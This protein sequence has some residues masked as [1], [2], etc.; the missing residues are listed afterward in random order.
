MKHCED[1]QVLL[2]KY[3]LVRLMGQQKVSPNTVQAYKDTFRLY[4]RYLN[5]DI[6]I[7]PNS[8]NMSHFTTDT[9]IGFLK[10]LETKRNN[11]AK[12]INN[13]LAAI[14][15]FLEFV[16]YESPEYLGNIRKIK[17]IPFRKT[18]KKEVAYL[19]KNEI[20]ALLGACDQSDVEGRRDY[21]M[22]LLLYNTG[23][24]VSELVSL[25]GKDIFSLDNL[26]G[27]IRIYGKG[28]KERSVPLWKS[29][30]EYLRNYM[31]A[32]GISC[33]DYLLSG[34][35]VPHLT[36]SGIRYRI[37]CIVLRASD[38]CSSLRTKKVTAHVF[39]HS[40][41]MS[42]LQSGVDISTIAI[43]LGHESIETTHKY[44]IADLKLK[45][46]ALSKV[47]EPNMDRESH[48]YLIDNDILQF[49][50]LL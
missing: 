46:H 47:Q 31:K 40:T 45:E 38:N 37:E 8:V 10:Y 41:A 22:L 28:R 15:S 7:S 25:K 1:F 6:S 44:M 11:T 23:M 24:R 12:T 2:Q 4:L 19:T 36:R 32:H 49:L 48:R 39:R 18:D 20:D 43:W 5:D 26:K 21:M 50:A 16:S 34:R 30:A 35:N 27:Y 29:T 13:R 14:K 17:A 42:M 9:I 3:F 33:D